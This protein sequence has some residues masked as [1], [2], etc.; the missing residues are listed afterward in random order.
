MF[1]LLWP[2]AG[3]KERRLALIESTSIRDQYRLMLAITLNGLS[4]LFI[5]VALLLRQA[6]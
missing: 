3:Q 5:N 2:V 4:D 6:P 1:G